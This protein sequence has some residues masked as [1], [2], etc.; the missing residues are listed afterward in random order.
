M[1]YCKSC[2]VHHAAY[3]HTNPSETFS[4]WCTHCYA[5]H[6]R[7]W[8]Y[9][10]ITNLPFLNQEGENVTDIEARK[11]VLQQQINRA[12]DE[13]AIINKFDGLNFDPG[14]VLRWEV[15]R[16]GDDG[17]KMYAFAIK[18]GPHWFVVGHGRDRG[19]CSFDTV[20]AAILAGKSDTVEV[21]DIWKKPGS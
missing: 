5:Y 16:K 3:K 7:S 6:H 11:E 19:A 20:L 10:Q 12:A 2:G 21:T 17:E 13:L 18:T 1:R 14:T 15:L 9:C 8:G 4:R